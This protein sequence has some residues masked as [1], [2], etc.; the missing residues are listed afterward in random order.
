[1]KKYNLLFISAFLILLFISCN[2]DNI[3]DQNNSQDKMPDIE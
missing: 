2:K 3:T 1:M